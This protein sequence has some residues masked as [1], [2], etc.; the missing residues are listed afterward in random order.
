MKSDG[1]IG[2]LA[3]ILMILCNL[4]LAQEGKL[5]G[6]VSDELGPLA[7]ATIYANEDYHTVSD[8]SGNFQLV[9]PE[10]KYGVKFSFVGTIPVKRQV[11][12]R[13]GETTS[14]DIILSANAQL[15]EVVVTG[16]M[17][18]SYIADSPVKIDVLGARQLESYIPAASASAVEGITMINGVEEVVA[19]GVC[20]TNSHKYQR[21]TGTVHR[22]PDGWNANVWQPC[23]R[24]R[25]ERD[26]EYDRRQ[27]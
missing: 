8:S 11:V 7:F 22:S 10:G 24:L 26:T 15:Q 12:I 2:L 18:A 27:V 19:C 17:K 3:A 13:A 16:T 4:S 21:A 9:L 6:T 20:F 5:A 25:P 1:K 14:L 23:L